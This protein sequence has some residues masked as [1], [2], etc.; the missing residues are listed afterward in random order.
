MSTIQRRHQTIVDLLRQEGGRLSVQTLSERLGVS[1]VTIRQDLRTLAANDVLERVYGGAVLRPS[2]P[3]SVEMSFEVRQGEARKAK[4]AMGRFAAQ[5]VKD[6][7]GIAMDGSTSVYAMVP[8]LKRM[9]NLTIVTNSLMVAQSFRDTPRVKV[10]IPAGR[11]RG[12]S[13]TIVS[14]PDSLPD[15]N[16]SLGFF[17]AWGVSLDGGLSDV[18]PDE[19][20]MRQSLIR[21]C[22]R[23]VV[24]VDSRKWGETA[25][26]TYAQPQDVNRIISNDG[27]PPEIVEHYE[28]LGVSVDLVPAG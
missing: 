2:G 21:R 8:Y 3:M 28:A 1:S 14:E 27:A 16:L 7:S 4:D 24:V 13:A 17:G 10:L 9:N 6:G 18:D 20:V 12:E 26:Y 11:I 19:V 25:P 15:I 22:L 23:T 5:L